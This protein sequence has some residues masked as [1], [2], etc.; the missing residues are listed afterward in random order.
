MII[1]VRTIE[2]YNYILDNPEKTIKEIAEDMSIVERKIR[3]EIENLN[4]LLSLNN[5]KYRIMNFEGKI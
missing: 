4:F 5:I 2:V 3:Y 1:N